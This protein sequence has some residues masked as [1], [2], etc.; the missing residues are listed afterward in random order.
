MAVLYLAQLLGVTCNNLLYLCS[1]SWELNGNYSY[2]VDFTRRAFGD[3]Y[4]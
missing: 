3:I 1:T 2:L 4:N